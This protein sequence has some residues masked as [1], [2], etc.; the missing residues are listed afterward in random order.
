[1][2]PILAPTPCAGLQGLQ[3]GLQ[4]KFGAKPGE[5]A[6]GQNLKEE[7]IVEKGPRGQPEMREQVSVACRDSEL[8]ERE[9]WSPEAEEAGQ[10]VS[11]GF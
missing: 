5:G 6:S 11:R 1:M 3:S 8:K 10:L 7:S 4:V 9:K 2:G